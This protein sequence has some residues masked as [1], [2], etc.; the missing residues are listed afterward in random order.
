MWG[1]SPEP[2]IKKERRKEEERG[3]EKKERKQGRN[4][5]KKGKRKERK[6]KGRR[7]EGES[8]GKVLRQVSGGALKGRGAVLSGAPAF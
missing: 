7:D 6:R 4:E 8:Q 5:G 2:K 3:R 1:S